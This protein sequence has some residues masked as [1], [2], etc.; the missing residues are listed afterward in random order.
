MIGGEQPV[1]FTASPNEAIEELIGG[2]Y[3]A[4]IIAVN[5]S[6]DQWLTMC[7]DIR[8]NPRLYNLPILMVADDDSFTDPSEPFRQGATDLVRRPLDGKNLHARLS[9]LIKQQ[10]FRGRMQEVY[11]RSLHI[12]TSDSLTGLYSYGFLHDYLGKLIDSNRHSDYP[13]AVGMFDV[14][15]M[16]EI[17]RRHGYAAGDKLL[18]QTG[19]L[20]GRL[21]RGE[22]LVARYGGQTFC[23][24][25]PETGYEDASLVLRRIANIVSMTE[26]GVLTDT[27]PVT[28]HL[29]LG[30]A[31][32]EP[33]DSAEKL[34]GKALLRLA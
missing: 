29:R 20:I 8:D 19:S 5:G 32:L 2:R 3:E 13:V 33:G 17:N 23:V 16:S 11:S 9:M 14:K 31:M 7:A 28:V 25:M 6:A 22:D 18:R 26:L 15:A 24:V 1:A 21:V 4:A 34:L 30:A 12:E 27:N 10:R